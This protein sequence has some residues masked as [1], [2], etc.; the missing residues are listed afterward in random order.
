VQLRA[1][2][3]LVEVTMADLPQF[4][5]PRRV[6]G[7]LYWSRSEVERYKA[8]LLGKA[9][10]PGP[11]FVEALVPSGQITKEFGVGRRTVGRWILPTPPS[12]Q[13]V[14]AALTG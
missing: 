11:D 2:S 3:E 10:E 6:H 9:F 4:P 5:Q 13:L 14:E 1:V 12:G 7:R 8:A